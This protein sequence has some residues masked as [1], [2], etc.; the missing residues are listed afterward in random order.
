MLGFIS[1]CYQLGSILAVPIT[2]W[3]NRKYGRRWCIMLGSLIMVVGALLQG[4]A[5]NGKSDSNATENHE[6][7]ENLV[8][9]YIVARMLLGVGILFAIISGSALIGELAYPKERPTM[10]SLFNASYFIGSIVA[11][12][13]AIRTSTIPGDWSWRIPSLLQICPSMLQICTVL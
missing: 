10:T 1:S 4:F 7:R 11:A 2:P 12:A 6:L 13:I 3:I 8:G 5:Q 9:M